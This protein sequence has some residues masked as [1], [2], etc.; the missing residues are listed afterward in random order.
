LEKAPYLYLLPEAYMLLRS[1]MDQNQLATT[2]RQHAVQ[3]S[4][5]IVIYKPSEKRGKQLMEFWKST[6]Y[7]RLMAN[8]KCNTGCGESQVR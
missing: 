6:Q 7:K 1:W 3:E 2:V 4:Y 8:V 5:E